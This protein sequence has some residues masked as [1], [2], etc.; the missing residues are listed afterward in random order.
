M[1]HLLDKLDCTSCKA[2]TGIVAA[3]EAVAIRG[4]RIVVT[5]GCLIV[6]CMELGG[7]IDR[8]GTLPS[9]DDLLPEET[10]IGPRGW[11]SVSRGKSGRFL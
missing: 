7:V 11:S 1:T 10:V 9:E 6:V 3:K 4:V 5:R 2:L 8:C